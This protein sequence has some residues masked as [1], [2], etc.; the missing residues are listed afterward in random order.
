MAA[1]HGSAAKRKSKFSWLLSN[2]YVAPKSYIIAKIF[3]NGVNS[4]GL[5]LGVAPGVVFAVGFVFT[6]VKI[7]ALTFPRTGVGSWAFA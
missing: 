2:L 7:L 1:G 3:T 6:Y 5:W 4:T